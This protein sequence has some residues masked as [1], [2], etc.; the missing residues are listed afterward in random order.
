MEMI[1]KIS[2]EKIP[3]ESYLT[4]A[5]LQTQAMLQLQQFKVVVPKLT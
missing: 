5:M 2:A 3:E 1:I 4:K